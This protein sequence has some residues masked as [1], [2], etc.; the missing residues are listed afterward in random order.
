VVV[1]ELAAAPTEEFDGLAGKA[2]GESEDF[3]DVVRG[4]V[5]G[6]ALEGV[7][8]GGGGGGGDEVTERF[9]VGRKVGDVLEGREI[10]ALGKWRRRRRRRKWVASLSASSRAFFHGQ[11]LTNKNNQPTQF[12][13]LEQS[14][15]V[16][17]SLSSYFSGFCLW[18]IILIII[19]YYFFI[20]YSFLSKC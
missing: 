2:V 10:G 16:V 13:D 14:S 7:L 5:N 1:A 8:D 12:Q 18:K 11:T 6:G 15:N 9:D 3:L 17:Y 4:D 19:Y 20:L